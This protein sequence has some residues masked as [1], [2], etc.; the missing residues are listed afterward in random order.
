MALWQDFPRRTLWQAYY[1]FEKD[2]GWV[3]AGHIAF[4][5]LF[6]IFPFLILLLA[7]AA[8]SARARRR[9]ASIELARSR[10][11]RPMWPA[12]SGRPSRR[13]ATPRTP[14]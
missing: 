11:C 5:G 3:I 2:N 7:V 12:A 10:S 8:C 1:Q 9:T 6:A 13:C 14:G 4:M